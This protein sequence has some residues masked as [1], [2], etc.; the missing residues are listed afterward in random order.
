MTTATAT[1]TPHSLG[2]RVTGH[3]DQLTDDGR[4]SNHASDSAIH[5]QAH[6]RPPGFVFSLRATRRTSRDPGGG[7]KRNSV[8]GSSGFIFQSVKVP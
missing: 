5:A 7:V 3:Q 1:T 8:S 6:F 2:E 4:G